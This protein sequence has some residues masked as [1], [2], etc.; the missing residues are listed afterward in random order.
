M[1]MLVINGV[2][3]AF[4]HCYFGSVVDLRSFCNPHPC[5]ISLQVKGLQVLRVIAVE[6]DHRVFPVEP[7]LQIPNF[8]GTSKELP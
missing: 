5:K 6:V 3:E 1:S 4:E 8:K 7:A 2:E